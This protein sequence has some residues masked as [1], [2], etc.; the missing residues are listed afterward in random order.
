MG[1][2]TVRLVTVTG[3]MPAGW[4]SPSSIAPVQIG[5][6][7]RYHRTPRRPQTGGAINALS[8]LLS[9]TCRAI[10]LARDPTAD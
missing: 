7:R 2:L 9:Q 10:M 6:L 4:D 3:R 1:E 8:R 5:L